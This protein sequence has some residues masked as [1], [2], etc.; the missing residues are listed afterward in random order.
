MRAHAEAVLRVRV[1]LGALH[2]G[3]SDL[4][5]GLLVTGSLDH[6]V[7]VF[8]AAGLLRAG[9]ER[10]DSDGDDPYDEDEDGDGNGDGQSDG[11][12]LLG[13]RASSKAA[14]GISRLFGKRGYWIDEED[15]ALV[16]PGG[17]ATAASATDDERGGGAS[18]IGAELRAAATRVPDGTAL[19]HAGGVLVARLGHGHA[20]EDI[21][22]LAAGSEASTG[23]HRSVRAAA[24]VKA[25]IDSESSGAR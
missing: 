21:A 2:G 7:S 4:R 22:V 15:Q 11:F 1:P 9:L 6:T 10:E 24:R 12:G 17:A 20:V 3:A 13:G 23:L 5:G 8:S 19:A 16:F 14:T 18:S 25:A